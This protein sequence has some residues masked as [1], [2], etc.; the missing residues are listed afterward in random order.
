M[1]DCPRCGTTYRV[2]EKRARRDDASYECAR[3]GLVFGST[4]GA[5]D[6]DWRDE[7][8]E[9]AL[10]FDDEAPPSPRSGHRRTRRAK[11]EFEARNDEPTEVDDED[12]PDEDDGDD[13]APDANPAPVVSPRRT[14]P[15]TARR[16]DEEV[17]SP[18]V[19]RFA[20]RVLI[21]VTL[22]YAVVSVWASTHADRFQGLLGRIPLVGAHLAELP[23]D[24]GDV[25]LRDVQGT[26]D[27][28]QS[29]ELVFVIRAR[30]A[31]LATRPLRRIR[32]E[33]RVSGG[34]EQRARASCTDTPAEVR[35]TSRQM[36]ALMADVREARPT[37]VPAGGSIACEVVFVTPPRP[38]S[39]LSLEVVSVV[40][41]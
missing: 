26:Y 15:R 41:D 8:E 39:E 19:A 38:L 34:E 9:E 4:P 36:L 1:V 20:L 23:L 10:R 5:E 22:I 17:E 29:G 12:P 14:K 2:P 28:L 35:K 16:D 33:G 27:H 11:V 3:C 32:V 37:P 24:P 18:G 40:A 13:E 7:P 21:A 6:D 30:A 25:A 31:N